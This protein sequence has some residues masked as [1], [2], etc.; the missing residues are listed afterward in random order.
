V[1]LGIAGLELDGLPEPFHGPA[2][3]QA[4]GAQ[5]PH[6]G[7]GHVEQAGR[8]VRRGQLRFELQRAVQGLFDFRSYR[9]GQ[10]LVV[11]VVEQHLRVGDPHPGQRVVVIALQ[12]IAK[13]HQR[14]AHA[15]L[16][17]G[18]EKRAALHVARVSLKVIGRVALALAGLASIERLFQ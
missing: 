12:R 1:R 17:P 2:A 13:I 8:G 5:R 15:R 6:R 16:G 9:L 18:V 14:L 7:V 11:V 3:I 4:F 10:A